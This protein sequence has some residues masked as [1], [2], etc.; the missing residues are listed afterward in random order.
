[1][2][3]DSTLAEA[4]SATRY[5]VIDC[6]CVIRIGQPM[7][8]ALFRWLAEHGQRG[9]LWLITADNPGAQPT[10]ATIN[11][12]RRA[13]LDDLLDRPGRYTCQTVHED[14]DHVWP[15]EYGR[16]IAGLDTGLACALG[17]RFGQA[18]IVG[19]SPH[20]PARLVWLDSN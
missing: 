14:P 5:R 1:M 9:A 7:P 2:S 18:A 4:F 19:L 17:R 20:T 12:A 3:P 6:D 10:G 13:V 15:H 11:A 16:L 8:T